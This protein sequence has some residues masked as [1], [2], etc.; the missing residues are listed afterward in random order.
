MRMTLSRF[1]QEPQESD[2]AIVEKILADFKPI[3]SIKPSSEIRAVRLAYGG[4]WMEVKTAQGDN[5]FDASWI[6][7]IE[8]ARPKP[9]ETTLLY[10][11]AK[12]YVQRIVDKRGTP[13]RFQ[14]R[15]DN[16]KILGW[17]RGPGKELFKWEDEFLT[18]PGSHELLAVFYTHILP[19]R[20][21]EAGG[22]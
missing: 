19:R 4:K 5:V 1:P 16:E 11:A 22:A 8:G 7:N 2:E 3:E 15:S 6:E 18:A 13:S 17:L 10:T 14:T 20:R 9:R 21:E 12:E